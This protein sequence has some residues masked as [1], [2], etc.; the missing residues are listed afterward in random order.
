MRDLN[1][2]RPGEINNYID[3][4]SLDRKNDILDYMRS[5]NSPVLFTSQPVKDAVTGEEL[6]KVD[7]GYSDGK[8]LWFESE[9]YHFDKYNLKLEDDFIKYVLNKSA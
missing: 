8:Y 9:I 1:K 6:K 5:G 2:M 4:R 7:N 3:S